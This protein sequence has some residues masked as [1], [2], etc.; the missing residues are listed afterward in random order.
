LDIEAV[1]VIEP[2][3]ISDDD[4]RRAGHPS[5]AVLLAE[6]ERNHAGRSLYRIRF[7]LAGGDERVALREQSELS[8]SEIEAALA[9]LARLDRHGG[10]GTWTRKV[11][12]AIAS[13]PGVLA[14]DLAARLGYEKMWFKTHVRKLKALGLTESLE[15]G[16]RISPRGRKILARM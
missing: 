3:A 15:I 14:A 13:A 8:D 5:R 7:R 9:A 1:D 6:L 2:A 16:Y 10:Q 12:A 11:L 4:A